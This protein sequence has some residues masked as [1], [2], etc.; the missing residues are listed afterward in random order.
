MKKK[1]IISVLSTVVVIL[2][3][4]TLFTG[5]TSNNNT[6][7]FADV[8]LVGFSHH[9]KFE[10][11]SRCISTLSFTLQNKGNSIAEN[12]KL[13]VDVWD[14][15]GNEVYNKEVTLNSTLDPDEEKVQSIDVIYDL[16]DTHLDADVSINWDGGVN[17]YTK[18]FE[19]EYKE[20]TDV[21]LESMTHHES[22]NLSTGYE[23]S[24]NLLLRNR[25]NMIAEFV[26]IH[27]LVYDNSGNVEYNKE[28]DVIPSLLPW[29]IKA[30]E[31]KIPYDFDD[32]RLDLTIT[33]S[34]DGGVN[35]YNRS[36]EPEFKEYADVKL[37][38]M[39]HYEHYKLFVGYV[40]TVT[41]ILQNKG[42]VPADNVKIHVI[43]H[44]N[45]DNEEYNSEVTIVPVLLPGEIRPHEIT[46]PYDFDDARLDLTIT[47]SW[48]DGM[49]HYNRSFE[50]KIF[51]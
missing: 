44:D 2:L 29:E 6:N 24:V 22:Y 1:M 46:I 50:P 27:V 4:L 38:S 14:N 8:R 39:T 30:I 32:T 41:L 15:N 18:S 3:L 45:N 19:P 43:A 51:F 40:S 49:N 47:V 5:C 17:H 9:Q 42:S 21:I 33:V 11:P 34:W 23:T 25:G 36:F 37:D 28:E 31:I 16:N 35:Q 7:D 13:H 26:G 10:L 48:D 12:I 20:Y